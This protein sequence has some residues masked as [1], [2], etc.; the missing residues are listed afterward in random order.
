M[1]KCTECGETISFGEKHAG[2][3]SDDDELVGFVCLPCSCSLEF[4]DIT[5]EM[6]GKPFRKEDLS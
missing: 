2:L 6:T 4:E 5:E 1:K 3:W